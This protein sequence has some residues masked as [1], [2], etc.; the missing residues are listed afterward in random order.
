L[1]SVTDFEGYSSRSA[2]FPGSRARLG[3]TGAGK[4][5]ALRHIVEHLLAAKK[6]VCIIDPKGD[7]WGLKAS[8]DGKG[9]GFPV[10]AFGDFKNAEASDVPINAQSGR[11]VAELITSGNR[12]CII[13]FRGWM[14]SHMVQFWIDLASGIFN[15]NSGELYLV[16]D[17]FHN[18]A[19]KGKIMDPQ[20]GK[21][22]HWSN[23][24]LSEGR[25]LGIVC[26]IASQRPQKVHNDTLTS[27]ETLVAMR[28]IHAADRGAVEEWIK[29]AGDKSLGQQVLNSLAQMPRGSGWVW[30][31]EIGY[32]PEIVEFP[33]FT[34]FDSFA[35]P[36]LQKKVSKRGWADVNLDEVK[37]RLET[38]IKEHEANDPRVLRAQVAELRKQLNHAQSMVK[39][40]T[41]VTREVP[42][43]SDRQ[44]TRIEAWLDRFERVSIRH[45]EDAI[46]L[47]KVGVETAGPIREAL[48]RL[49]QPT[50]NTSFLKTRDGAG[51]VAAP[52]VREVRTQ[53]PKLNGS[54]ATGAPVEDGAITGVMQRILD[55]LA[56]LEQLGAN[57]PARELV[58][59]M[60]NYT[61]LRSKG[62]S[63]AIGSLRT[64][65]LIDYPNSGSIMLTEA[66]R[67]AASYRTAPR[68]A[69]EVQT[70]ICTLLGG[71]S[72][73]ILQPL[74]AAYP[75]E[76]S[77]EDVAAAA[78]YGNLRSKGFANAIGRLRSL[79]FVDYPSQGTIKANP[80][81][82]LEGVA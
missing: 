71:A 75:N 69:E 50:P 42:V 45:Q 33:M 80:V 17:E 76:L 5:S 60:A 30:S 10:V 3:K 46:S 73:R 25:G 13:G 27:C 35:P 2:L 54:G 78:G 8:A 12:P 14:T 16:G 7:W 72:S 9:A 62:F 41:G 63:N 34:T 77:R 81:L 15:A 22:L 6:R 55:A 32:G 24:L 43:L 26:L 39:I 68:T 67:A 11:H 18:F 70:R 21:C 20:A 58:A 38:V 23:R 19:P 31:P 44:L 61:N 65:G 82:F 47:Q 49:K 4:S 52:P 59:F 40:E 29:G 56:E 66:G 37:S 74:I 1:V 53:A 36:Q 48:V 57:Q 28:V 79:G 64:S 51:T